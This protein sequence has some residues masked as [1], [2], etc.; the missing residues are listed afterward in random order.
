MTGWHL[1]CAACTG[2]LPQAAN[3]VQVA[4]GATRMIQQCTAT[5]QD[6]M[7]AGTPLPT[8]CQICLQRSACFAQITVSHGAQAAFTAR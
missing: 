2:L 6:R 8:R 4:E 5:L 3:C 1:S 7:G